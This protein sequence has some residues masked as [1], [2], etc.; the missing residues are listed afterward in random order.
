MEKS[1]SPKYKKEK[2][3]TQE[4]NKKYYETHKDKWEAYN[5]KEEYYDCDLCKCSVKFA[6]KSKH[7]KTKKHQDALNKQQEQ[8]QQQ[9][10]LPN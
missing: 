2:L 1:L 5:N 3:T 6:H 7:F 9:E 8:E 10:E 4:Y